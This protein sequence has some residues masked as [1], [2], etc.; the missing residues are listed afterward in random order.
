MTGNVTPTPMTDPPSTWTPSP[1]LTAALAA[2]LIDIVRRADEQG[3]R[4]APAA[5]EEAKR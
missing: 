4:P 1:A 5:G 3:D 2:L